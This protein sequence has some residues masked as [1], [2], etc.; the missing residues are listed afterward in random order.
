MV[1]KSRAK[2]LQSHDCEND[3]SAISNLAKKIG[4]NL[5]LPLG[6]YLFASTKTLWIIE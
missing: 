6:L 3:L 2:D 5:A 1:V 4:A